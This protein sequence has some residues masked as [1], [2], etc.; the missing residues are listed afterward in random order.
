[1]RTSKIYNLC[2][3]L[4]IKHFIKSR[5]DIVVKKMLIK[6]IEKVNIKMGENR[7]HLQ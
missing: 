4:K 6:E 5:I 7:S 1:M 3:Y 2:F